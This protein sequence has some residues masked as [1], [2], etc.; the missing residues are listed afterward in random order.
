M[1]F[2]NISRWREIAAL[3]LN[4]VLQPLAELEV[5]VAPLLFQ[6]LM[7]TEHEAALPCKMESA[8][9]LPYHSLVLLEADTQS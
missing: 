4:P 5:K 7:S 6:G 8:K 3:D 9:V 2:H 1:T